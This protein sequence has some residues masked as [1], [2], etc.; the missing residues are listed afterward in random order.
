MKEL[1]ALCGDNCAECPR[2]LARSDEELQA[3]AELW[4]RIG[5]RDKILPG[6][7]MRCAGCTPGKQCTY[8]LVDCTRA[9]GVDTCGSCDEF[10]C[11]KIEEML[12]RSAQYQRI[13]R[14]RCSETEY[15][16]LER[17][18]FQKEKNIWK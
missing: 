4:C 11:G 12:N 16:A 17:A 9:H 5:W 6:E 18:F 3:V 2:Y 10:P 14:E 7:E 1:I 15:A 8:R 13:C